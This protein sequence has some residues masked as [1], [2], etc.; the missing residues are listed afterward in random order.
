MAGSAGCSAVNASKTG[1]AKLA[2][3][4]GTLRAASANVNFLRNLNSATCGSKGLAI[5]SDYDITIAQG[6]SDAAGETGELILT[7]SGAKTLSGAST[8]SRIV[9]A[10]GTVVFA[11][12]A[13]ASGTLVVTNGAKVVFTGDPGDVGL[14]GLVLGDSSTSGVLSLSAGQTLAVGGDVVVNSAKV[15][16]VGEFAFGS[17][18]ALLTATGVV[19][20]ESA[21]AWAD[22]LISS[23]AVEAYSYD[24]L[25]SSDGGVTSLK[26]GVGDA[27]FRIVQ[28]T[29]TRDYSSAV[30]LGA[31]AK[32]FVAVSNAATLA[33]S[34]KVA[35][36]AV[37]KVGEG[38][39][40][41]TNPGNVLLGGIV[42]EAGLF[43]V[44]TAAALGF[45][46]GLDV[47]ALRG[48]TLEFTSTSPE[49][50]P[51][52]IIVDAGSKTAAVVR[53]AGD[54]VVA[55]LSLES[56]DLV[57][58]GAG[59]LVVDSTG[60]GEVTLTRDD[61]T[62]TNGWDPS[63]HAAD[64]NDSGIAPTTGY[65]GLNVAEGALVLKGDASATFDAPNCVMVGMRTSEGVA[66]PELVVDGAKANLATSGL[67][68]FCG[69]Q[70]ASTA[71][72]RPRFTL[73]NGA[74]VSVATF[75]VGRGQDYAVTT[76]PTTT[77]DNATLSVSSFRGGYHG[78]C[79]HGIVMRNGARLYATAMLH[80]GPTYFDVAN[81][82]VQKNA[83]GD[84]TAVS[85]NDKAGEWTFRD[86]SYL[87]LN[88]MSTTKTS[89]ADAFT[90]NF[91]GGTWE[92]GG[93]DYQTFHLCN[94]E[95]FII[96]ATGSGGLT[97]PVAHGKTVNV[98]RAISG[99]GPIVK[100]G[101]G[102][103]VFETQ[104]TWDSALTTKTPLEDGV[105]LATTGLLDVREGSV[106]I[107]AGACR[108]G[109]SYRAAQGSSVDF[110]GNSV[111][112]ASFSG[113]GE[114]AAATVSGGKIVVPL[115][116]DGSA[117]AAPVFSSMAF[118]GG[119]KVDFGRD[120]PPDGPAEGLVVATFPD[121]APDVSGWRS[122][123]TGKGTRAT[124]RVAANG[125][126]VLADIKTTGFILILR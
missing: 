41:L 18:N 60:G 126:D 117:E 47:F 82:A 75:M 106:S 30:E 27:A 10:G 36:G 11:D 17:T 6:F 57:K 116:D 44:P 54:L 84:C 121:G 109:G 53:N 15:E 81:S 96:R 95:M 40:Y 63:T 118:S 89:A 77:V 90:I 80:Y 114:F 26:M 123:N 107:H 42:S 113:A 38:K 5:E 46:G 29:G 37:K 33:M 2:G 13:T 39:F 122:R 87:A 45:G 65:M 1:T 64:L 3:N 68:Q 8:V 22:A 111:G 43:S 115:S 71:A 99:D 70:T 125:K 86:G 61:G 97:L 14:N 105:S 58:R 32:A 98:A 19:S 34:G 69:Y 124:F 120:T 23:G 119:V 55:G 101:A 110:C 50:L 49:S 102:T 31:S 73:V 79:N 66:Q 104:G 91:D 12:G 51:G 85:F 93:G 72:L 112:A 16:L 24:F 35:R 100:T 28:E 108:S 103:L 9:A 94:A 52:S 88:K 78:M 4:G 92:T 62:S 83:A 76:W 20:G 74:D 25:V 48:G 59:R 7:G 67:F 56:G 21:A